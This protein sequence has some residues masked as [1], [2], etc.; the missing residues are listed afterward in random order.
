MLIR[1]KRKK[2]IGAKLRELCHSGRLPRVLSLWG[3]VGALVYWTEFINKH[4]EPEHLWIIWSSM[5]MTKEVPFLSSFVYDP[6]AYFQQYE[7]VREICDELASEIDKQLQAMLNEYNGVRGFLADRKEKLYPYAVA[8]VRD[9]YQKTIEDVE[10][11]GDD[12]WTRNLRHYQPDFASFP[13][14]TIPTTHER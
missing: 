10:A 3:A 2:D 12:D 4:D 1:H 7:T 11:D 14:V 5:K 13:Y 9:V 6:V 8:I